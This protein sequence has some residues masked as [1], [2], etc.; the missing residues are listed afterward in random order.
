MAQAKT[1]Y[2]NQSPWAIPVAQV[3]SRAGQ[4]LEVDSDFPAPSGIGDEF[5]GVEEGSSV[6]V[7]ARF[8]SIVDGLI[9]TA[10][11]TARVTGECGRCLTPIDRDLEIHL[12]SFMP[13]ED[14]NAALP[15]TRKSGRVH[16]DSEDVIVAGEEESEDINPLSPGGDFANIETLL[17]D[18][19]TQEI[20][21]TP[22]C[23][24]DCLGLCPQCG[25]N[26]NEHPDHVH[27]VTDIRLSA[28]EGLKAQLEAQ[29]KNTEAK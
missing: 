23:R 7:E 17:R 28:L 4:S 11:A 13:Y 25:I 2:P 20:P 24:P 14:P 9:F 5:Y 8:D 10:T 1:Q 6:A 12:T 21:P 19:F 3:G 22:L 15:T 16:E 27:E 26:L 29:Q 18:G